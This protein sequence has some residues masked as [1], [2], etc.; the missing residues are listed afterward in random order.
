MYH[1]YSDTVLQLLWIIVWQHTTCCSRLLPWFG[2]SRSYSMAVCLSRAASSRR[3]VPGDVLVLLRGKAPCD[4]VLIRG[5]CLVEESMLSGEASTDSDSM[6]CPPS[7][8]FA[9]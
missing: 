8:Y 5:S 7:L 4:M 6:L 1:Y 2:T 3:L 9:T